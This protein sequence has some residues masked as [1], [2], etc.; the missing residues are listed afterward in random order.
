MCIAESSAIQVATLITVYANW[1]F[2]KIKGVGWKWAG[3]VWV[4]TIITYFPLDVLKFFIRY[5][6]SGKAWDN[7]LQ[8]K[9]CASQDHPS[10]WE[11]FLITIFELIYRL[12]YIPTILIKY[13]SCLSLCLNVDCFHFKERLWKGREGSTMGIGSKNSAWP[14][15]TSRHYWS[16]PRQEQLQR[17]LGDRRTGKETRRGCPVILYIC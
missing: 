5:A 10:Y 15:A 4:Y 1:S 9:V 11:Y 6:L 17:A 16:F 7:L 8:N 2:A 14:S 3:I 13:E 12:K